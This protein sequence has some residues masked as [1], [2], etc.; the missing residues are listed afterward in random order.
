MGEE[1]SGAVKPAAS[2]CTAPARMQVGPKRPLACLFT[3]FSRPGEGKNGRHVQEQ[4]R[5]QTQSVRHWVEKM[6]GSIFIC[7]STAMVNGVL[8]ALADVL[9]GGRPAV[10]ALRK[11]NRI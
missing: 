3:A 4:V 1:M 7:G 2:G 10:D 5:A 9:E 8:E 6:E 11:H